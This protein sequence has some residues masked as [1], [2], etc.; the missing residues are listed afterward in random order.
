MD[1]TPHAVHITLCYNLNAILYTIAV[2]LASQYSI[3]EV[4][5]RVVDRQVSSHFLLFGY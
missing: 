4:G 2:D 1:N 5:Y 3:H